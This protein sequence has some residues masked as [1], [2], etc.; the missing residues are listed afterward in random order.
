MRT[1]NSLEGEG[2]RE[3]IKHSFYVY[4]VIKV[5]I[6]L[7]LKAMNIAKLAF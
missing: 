2:K 4:S 7:K 1:A 6:P 3:I 5:Y